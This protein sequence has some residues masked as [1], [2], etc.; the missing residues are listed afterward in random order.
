MQWI[1][2][3][4]RRTGMIHKEPQIIK[5]ELD[6]ET[7]WQRQT[8]ILASHFAN[9]LG[10]QTEEYVETL[11]KFESPENFRHGFVPVIVENGRIPLPRMLEIAHV[12]TDFDIQESNDWKKDRFR[13]S[14]IPYVAWL[15][16]I[17]MEVE[18]VRKKLLKDKNVRGGTI[19]EAIAF[20]LIPT[21]IYGTDHDIFDVLESRS[22]LFPGSEAGSVYVPD[23]AMYE[24]PIVRDGVTLRERERR[25]RLY[26]TQASSDGVRTHIVALRT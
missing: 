18:K 14:N 20:S 24:V 15:N 19:H 1:E 22:L 26:S 10:F 16:I 3:R 5:H 13:T 11:P 9:E 17:R 2:R 12:G 6:L 8:E 4:L 23:L 25:L 7:E 21:S